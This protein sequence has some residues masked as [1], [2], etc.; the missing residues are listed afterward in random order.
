MQQ[1]LDKLISVKRVEIFEDKHEAVVELEN[2]AVNLDSKFSV[3][4]GSLS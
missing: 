4:R 2:A 1:F 3:R